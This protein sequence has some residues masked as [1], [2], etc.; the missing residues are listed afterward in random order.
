MIVT[1]IVIGMGIGINIKKTDKSSN[2]IMQCFSI[3]FISV[4]E[5]IIVLSLIGCKLSIIRFNYF[6][7]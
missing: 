5:N 1:V 6:R 7:I 2:I 3:L 4:Y